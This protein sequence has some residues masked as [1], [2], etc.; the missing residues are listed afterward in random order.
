MAIPSLRETHESLNLAL[1]TGGHW[2]VQ[3]AG[4]AG[5][6][7]DV[8]NTTHLELGKSIGQ[9]AVLS[10]VEIYFGFSSASNQSINTSNDLK[11]PKNTLTFIVVPRAVGTT[12][13]FNYLSTSTTTGSVRLV[14]I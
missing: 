7:A 10:D 1:G 11:L 13:Y 3:S 9:I 2:Q 4:T 6:S 12:V 5:S 14:K 8:A